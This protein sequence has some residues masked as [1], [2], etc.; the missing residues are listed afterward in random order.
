MKTV[1][2][3]SDFGCLSFLHYRKLRHSKS[4]PSL[5]VFIDKMFNYFAILAEDC[6]YDAPLTRV[7]VPVMPI[8]IS[9]YSLVQSPGI[10]LW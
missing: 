10:W 1:M 9:R 4:E 3:G 6:D 5:T 8:L 7:P 2:D